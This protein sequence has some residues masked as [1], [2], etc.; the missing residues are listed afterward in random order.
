M[1]MFCEKC[2]AQ[3]NNEQICPQCGTPINQQ[4][5]TGQP[6]QYQTYKTYETYSSQQP[7]QSV[8]TQVNPTP[9][10]VWCI[11]GA[12]L[13]WTGIIG[14][15]FSIIGL[16]KANTYIKQYGEISQQVKIGKILSIIGIV[17][18]SIMTIFWIIWITVMI[19]VGI[20]IASLPA[21][22]NYYY[23]YTIK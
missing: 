18:S 17:G 9:I 4:R 6:T 12:A 13:S 22:G 23:R 16:K 7:V 21:N 10:L 15:I 19:I 5:T 14:L 20:T 1:R 11:V 2:G 3:I 8:P